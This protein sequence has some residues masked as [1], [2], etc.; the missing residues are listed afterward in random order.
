MSDTSENFTSHLEQASSIKTNYSPLKSSQRIPN[1]SNSRVMSQSSF[2]SNKSP[3]SKSP[4]NYAHSYSPSPRSSPNNYMQRVQSLSQ[5]K[6]HPK[7]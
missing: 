3:T 7:N 2:T 1:R 5:K 4:Q 6:Q